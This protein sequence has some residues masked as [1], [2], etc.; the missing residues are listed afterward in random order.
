MSIIVKKMD[1]RLNN[2][3]TST[4]DEDCT[5]PRKEAISPSLNQCGTFLDSVCMPKAGLFRVWT[6]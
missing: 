6:I 4:W 1:I 3:K 2:Q 5:G